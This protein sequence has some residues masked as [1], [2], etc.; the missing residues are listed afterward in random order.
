MTFQRSDLIR[1]AFLVLIFAA[2]AANV[3]LRSK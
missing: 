2:F 3:C 1:Y